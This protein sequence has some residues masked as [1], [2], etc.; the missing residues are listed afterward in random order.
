MAST[1]D[2]PG[3]SMRRERDEYLTKEMTKEIR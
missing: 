1:G 3:A 2:A